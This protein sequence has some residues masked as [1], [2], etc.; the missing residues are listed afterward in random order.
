MRIRGDYAAGD[1]R[2]LN[3]AAVVNDPINRGW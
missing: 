2:V 1:G 3:V